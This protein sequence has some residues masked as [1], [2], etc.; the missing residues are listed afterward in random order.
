MV[1]NVL[2]KSYENATFSI[3]LIKVLD[4]KGIPINHCGI[5][6]NLPQYA[7]SKGSEESEY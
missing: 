1:K 4:I 6:S 3:A 5:P 7:K 2:K